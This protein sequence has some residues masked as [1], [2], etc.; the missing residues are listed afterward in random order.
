MAKDYYQV[1]GVPKG[2]S[3]DEI[4]KAFRKKAREYHP[5]VNRDN[6]KAA[7]D[8]FKEANEAYEVLSDEGKR[9]QYDQFGHDA[10]TQGGGNTA[11]GF[12]GQGGFGGFGGGFGGGQGGGFENIFDMFFG[13]QSGG[14]PQGPQRGADLRYDLDISFEDAAFGAEKKIKIR[15][16]EECSRCHGTGGEPGSKVETCPTCHGSGQEQ[17]LQNTPFGQMASSRTCSTCHGTGKKIEKPCSKCHGTGEEQ[18][19]REINV[20][21]PAGVDNGSRLRV[22]GE[23]EPGT[24]GG[25]KGDL[26]VYIYVRDHKVFER[27]NTD[28]ISQTTISFAQAALGATVKVQTLDGMVDLKVPAGTQTGTAFRLRGRG[29]PFLRN[30]DKRGD[31]HI[32]VTVSTPKKLND[33]QRQLLIQF[34]QASHEDMDALTV[35]KGFLDKIKDSLKL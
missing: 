26:Y 3:Q 16:H 18:V 7:E 23:G 1:L 29:I 8:K 30:P 19:T 20:K 28:V 12:S 34:A 10:F 32:V 2:A 33:K 27:N 24:K 17:V 5:D 15:R 13:G 31:H 9:A 11:G 25:P 14:R 22:S 35:E 6:P 4:K 21:I